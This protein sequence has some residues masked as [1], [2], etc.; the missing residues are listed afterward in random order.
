[1]PASNP[2]EFQTVLAVIRDIL[3]IA[4]LIIIFGLLGSSIFSKHGV[5]VTVD[6]VSHTLK[7]E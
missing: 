1:M 3:L 6:D 5:T 2:L 7:L 4:V